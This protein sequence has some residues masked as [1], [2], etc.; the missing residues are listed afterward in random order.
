MVLSRPA[1]GF[2]SNASD[3]QSRLQTNEVP[4]T[5]EDDELTQ[6][7]AERNLVT[8]R[9]LSSILLFFDS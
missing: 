2:E 4:D 7:G 8:L 6:R 5:L 9:P 3:E 1:L